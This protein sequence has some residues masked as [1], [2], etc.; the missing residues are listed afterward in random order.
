[1]N[2]QERLY[3]HSVKYPSRC[4]AMRIGLNLSVD[5]Y[6]ILVVLIENELRDLFRK[7]HNPHRFSKEYQR[8]RIRKTIM[9]LRALRIR[10]WLPDLTIVK[11]AA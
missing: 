2:I 7:R 6:A 9:L 3:R 11:E 1:M 8:E 10:E 4:G 5:H